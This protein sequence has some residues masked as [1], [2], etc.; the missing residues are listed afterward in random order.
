M[1]IDL[2]FIETFF[3]MNLPGV[4][5]LTVGGYLYHML[6]TIVVTYGLIFIIRFLI[7]TFFKK[8]DFIEEKKE[9]TIESVINNTSKYLAFF[10][11]VISAIQPFFDLREIMVAGGVLGIVIGFGAQSLIKDIF[12]GGFLVGER[13]FQ[14]GDFVHINGESEGGTVE[15]LGFRV[16]KI[17]LVSGKLMFV[18]NGEIKKVVNGNI[19]KRRIF[20]SVIV[21]FRESPEKMKVLLEEVCAEL[22]EKIPEYLI[23][24]ENG[25]YVEAYRYHGLSSLDVSPNG[26]KYSIAATIIDTEYINCVQEVKQI[27][28]QKMYDEN[29]KMAEQ[30]VYYQTRASVK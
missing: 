6:M 24:N 2:S 10:I 16:V 27:L 29:I 20:E 23:K 26:Y 12:T 8:T 4:K 22:N 11:V 21:S 3:N 7:H 30:Q 25:E 28:A 13:Q 5:E 14:I 17:R 9:Q 18:P 1:K 19:G 15:D